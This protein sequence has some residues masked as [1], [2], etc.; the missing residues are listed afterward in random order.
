MTED[1]PRESRPTPI[2]W[3]LWSQPDKHKT[4]YQDLALYRDVRDNPRNLSSELNGTQLG[5]FR[6]TVVGQ[7]DSSAQSTAASGKHLVRAVAVV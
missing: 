2:P 6:Q 5:V 3:G 7:F 4:T 1:T